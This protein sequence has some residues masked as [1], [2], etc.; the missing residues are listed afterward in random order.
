MGKKQHKC[1][2]CNGRGTVLY[3]Y[4]DEK[5]RSHCQEVTC[6]TC[7]GS[8]WVQKVDFSDNDIIFRWK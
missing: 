2:V 4:T 5:G 7:G 1:D 6:P 8:G 3:D